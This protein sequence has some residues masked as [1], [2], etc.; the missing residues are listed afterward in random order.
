MPEINPNMT[1]AG[2]DSA[3]LVP[4]LKDYN[5]SQVEIDKILQDPS[6]FLVSDVIKDP[7]GLAKVAEIAP[8]SGKATA[9]LEDKNISAFEEIFQM[10]LVIMA[11]QNKLQSLYSKLSLSASVNALENTKL[12]NEKVATSET[13]NAVAGM[14]SGFV[15]MGFSA[16]SLKVG[17]GTSSK[18]GVN[19]TSSP[20]VES[21]SAKAMAFQQI[22]SAIGGVATGLFGIFAAEQKKQ[23]SNILAEADFIKTAA[24]ALSESSSNMRNQMDTQAGAA[25]S[26]KSFIQSVSRN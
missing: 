11:D 19:A 16:Y 3:K 10:I 2:I 26:I 7:A 9:P 24:Q 12:G 21:I 25:E 13:L 15:S 4:I 6:L 17:A 14:V 22:G 8:P 1:F 23:G 18:T 5:V 20:S